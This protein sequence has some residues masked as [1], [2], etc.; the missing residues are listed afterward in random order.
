MISRLPAG[1]RN[2]FVAAHNSHHQ[3]FENVSKF[4]RAMSDALCT[5]ATGGG[6]RRR[7]L[8]TNTAESALGGARPVMMEGISNFITEPDLLDRSVILTPPRLPPA[9]RQTERRLYQAFD[10]YKPRIFGALLD[11]MTTGLKRV[12]ETDLDELPRMADFAT[13]VVA[14]GLDGF[15]QAFARNRQAAI[16]RALEYDPLAQR[17]ETF[18]WRQTWQ[19]S[20]KDLLSLLGPK[21]GCSSP[22]ELAD[23]LRRLTPALLTHGIRCDEGRR[24]AKRRPIIITRIE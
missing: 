2:L 15:E 24:E 21:C 6:Y 14:C 16:D 13:W 12:E 17:I 5:L 18:M 22:R 10:E 19:G 9:S 7:A 4:S 8:H 11:M 23:Q 20:A 3:A 1:P